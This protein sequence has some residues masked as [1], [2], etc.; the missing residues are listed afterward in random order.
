[1]LAPIFSV[2]GCYFNGAAIAIKE[3]RNR[4]G[5]KRFAI[6]GTDAHHGDGTWEIF[7]A[8]PDVLYVCFCGYPF[9]EENNKVNI[10][11]PVR[12][13]DEEYLRLVKKDLFPRV[14]LF[15]PEIIFWNWGYDGI[16]GEY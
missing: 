4:F 16:Q 8:D 14:K 2:G 3:L 13:K 6:I 15:R 1:M 10:Q 12:V 7:E 5:V 9:W 11:V